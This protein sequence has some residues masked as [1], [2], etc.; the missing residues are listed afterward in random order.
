M[1]IIS[2]KATDETTFNM[3]IDLS[4]N[5]EEIKNK[6]SEKKDIPTDQIRLIYKGILLH[7]DQ[8]IESYGIKGGDTVHFIKNEK[9]ANETDN[10]GEEPTVTNTPASNPSQ[11]LGN[12][13][14]N[15]A[16]NM[17]TRMQSDPQ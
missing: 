16:Q 2:I 7:N 6:I 1:K 3:R 14:M 8:T 10:R 4:K 13:F 17:W 11:T 5:T 9:P 12:M 15:T